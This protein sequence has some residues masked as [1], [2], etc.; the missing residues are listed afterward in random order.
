[1][2]LIDEIL[3]RKQNHEKR[4]EAYTSKAYPYGEK[5]KEKIRKIV[6]ELMPKEIVEIGVYNYLICK[7]EIGEIIEKEASDFNLN[8]V[9]SIIDEFKKKFNFK[10]EMNIYRCIALFEADL[11]IDENLNYPSIES[12]QDRANEIKRI[13]N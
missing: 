7:Q 13:L 8:I 5:Q 6:K 2:S 9:L 1:M 12:L 11:K 10:D 3:H 4:I